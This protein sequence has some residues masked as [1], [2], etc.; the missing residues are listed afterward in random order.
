MKLSIKNVE[1]KYRSE[2]FSFHPPQKSLF[3][4]CFSCPSAVSMETFL[5]LQACS[6]LR[7]VHASQL[8]KP[9]IHMTKLRRESKDGTCCGLTLSHT[10]AHNY[11]LCKYS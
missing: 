8:W 11:R 10:S 9:I 2:L 4:R 1:K 3:H 5:V 7:N 6:A